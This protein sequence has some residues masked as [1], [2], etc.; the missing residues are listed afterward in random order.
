MQ[1]RC[2]A[3]FPPK[4]TPCSPVRTREDARNSAFIF[5]RLDAKAK[6]EIQ[7]EESCIFFEITRVA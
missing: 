3:T 1:K 2:A 7:D 4:A 5:I 6:V